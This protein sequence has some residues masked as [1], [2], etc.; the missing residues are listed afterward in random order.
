MDF[1]ISKIET[2]PLQLI[3][4]WS[5]DYATWIVIGFAILIWI[6][7]IVRWLCKEPTAEQQLIDR[8]ITETLDGFRKKCFPDIPS[9]EPIDNNRVTIFK[10]VKCCWWVRPFR[11][12]CYPW[13]IGRSPWS[14]WLVVI[15]RS[16]HQTQRGAAVFLAPDDAPMSEGVVGQAWRRGAYRVGRHGRK[17]PNLNGVEYISFI[18]RAWLSVSSRLNSDTESAKKYRELCSDMT[19][20]ATAT[21]TTPAWIWHRIKRKKVI[22][23][24]ILAIPLLDGNGERWGVLVMDSSNEYECID[25]DESAFRTA[26][27]NLQKSLQKFGIVT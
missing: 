23:V 13:G 15:Q 20:Y 9:A 24:S 8:L 19:T 6:L 2:K 14:G 17:L 16:G 27:R 1:D 25:T 3:V 22:P 21:N 12:V 26:F 4:E 7:R 18:R 5:Q 10:H 11:S